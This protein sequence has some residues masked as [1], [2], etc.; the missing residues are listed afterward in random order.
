MRAPGVHDLFHRPALR[1]G[2]EIQEQE[3]GVALLYRDQSCDLSVADEGRRELLAL[4]DDLQRAPASMPELRASHPR[5]AASLPGLLEELDRLGLVTEARFELPADA[6]SGLEFNSRLRNLAQRAMR[7]RGRSRLYGML[8]DGSAPRNVLIGY[9][10]EYY[11]LVRAAPG[12]IASALSHADSRQNQRS[13]QRF[14]MSELDHDQML[15]DSLASVDMEVTGLEHLQPLPSTFALCSALGVFARQHLLSFKSVLFLFE[16]PG[17]QFN[18]ALVRCCERQGLAR[19]FWEPLLRHAHI[20]DTLGHDDITGELLEDISAIGRE[21]QLVVE[22]NLV[23]TVETMAL[24][25]EE[26]VAYYSRADAA[27]PRLY[28]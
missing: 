1:A 6:I 14:L 22:K 23:L 7:K 2:V 3:D 18:Q 5:M 20:N 8:A 28:L 12:L 19:T 16:M 9:A 25:D 15:A 17:E 27:M 10:L 11:C 24:Q 26:I 4:L 13:L 21:E